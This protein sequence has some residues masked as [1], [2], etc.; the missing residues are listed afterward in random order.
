MAERATEMAKSVANNPKVLE[1]ARKAHGLK[2]KAG[3][4]FS[5]SDAITAMQAEMDKAFRQHC[6][7]TVQVEWVFAVGKRAPAQLY[8][9]KARRRPKYLFANIQHLLPPKSKKRQGCAPRPRDL[10]T[11]EL[12]DTLALLIDLL[13][14]GVECGAISPLCTSIPQD[15]KSTCVQT[16]K[17]N[18]GKAWQLLIELLHCDWFSVIIMVLLENVREF[19]LLR[20]RS[21]FPT[22]FFGGSDDGSDPGHESSAD[23]DVDESECSSADDVEGFSQSF[24]NATDTPF[25]HAK[26]SMERLGFTACCSDILDARNFGDSQARCRFFCCWAKGKASGGFSQEIFD[27]AIAA[28]S[29]TRGREVP[30]MGDYLLSWERA[31]YHPSMNKQYL[32]ENRAKDTKQ[33][34]KEN[35]RAQILYRVAKCFSS[36]SWWCH[37]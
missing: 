3:A 16:Q 20:S 15:V 32:L 28:F 30:H 25:A 33:P 11:G 27:D 9:R 17:H 24:R 14:A 7:I 26:V 4:V 29:I 19:A 21:R 31:C 18:A 36:F 10:L 5:G 8:I 23:S 13:L 35:A 2:L 6:G 12:V 22:V 34:R 1:D 37:R